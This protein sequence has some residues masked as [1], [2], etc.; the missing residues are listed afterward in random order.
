MPDYDTSSSESVSEDELTSQARARRRRAL[1]EPTLPDNQFETTVESRL[2]EDQMNSRLSDRSTSVDRGVSSCTEKN[3]NSTTVDSNDDLEETAF[4]E[5]DELDWV[6][7]AT[8][9]TRKQ[10]LITFC[11][12][13]SYESNVDA[14]WEGRKFNSIILAE[15]FSGPTFSENFPSI[16]NI[17]GNLTKLWNNFDCYLKGFKAQKGFSDKLDTKHFK[18]RRV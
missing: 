1:G 13:I 5:L 18:R 10:G 6:T 4:G 8:I 16:P 2:D 9:L 3:P 15:S 17:P 12:L 11:L 7:D 14:L